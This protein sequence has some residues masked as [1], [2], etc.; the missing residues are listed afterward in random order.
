[1]LAWLAVAVA[2]LPARARAERL[3]GPAEL[4]PPRVIREDSPGPTYYRIPSDI[5][6]ALIRDSVGMAMRSGTMDHPGGVAFTFDLLAGAA[7]QLGR[8]SSWGLWSEAGYSYSR[9][10]DHLA[11]LGIGPSW[12]GAGADPITTPGLALIPHVVAGTIDGRDAVGLRTSLV[13]RS[14]LPFEIAHQVVIV[15][16]HAVHEV[17]L[18]LTF[19]AVFGAS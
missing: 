10:H 14:W 12:R 3:D 2:T 1:M 18:L 17:Q 13:G 19:P 8:G 6:R 15:D 5:L 7:F 4:P 11:L 9:F 16:G